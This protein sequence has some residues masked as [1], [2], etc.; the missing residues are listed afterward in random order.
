[1]LGGIHNL[2]KSEG[3]C[4]DNATITPLTLHEDSPATS[5]D[6]AVLF[7]PQATDRCMHLPV[8]IAGSPILH[9]SAK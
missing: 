5:V 8:T 9:L 7:E 2:G 4:E 3:F 6:F 1:M